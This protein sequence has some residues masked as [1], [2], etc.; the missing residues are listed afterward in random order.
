MDRPRMFH[1]EDFKE[2]PIGMLGSKLCSAYSL[3]SNVNKPRKFCIM[4][5]ASGIGILGS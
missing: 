3:V 5:I 4:N 2:D 1:V